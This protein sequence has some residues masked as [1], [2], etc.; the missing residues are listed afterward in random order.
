MKKLAI[1]FSFMLVCT[2]LYA[3]EIRYIHDILLVP[4]RSGQSIAHRIVH[5]GLRSGTKLVLLE[6][7]KETGYSKVRTSGG[8]EGWLQSQYIVSEPTAKLKLKESQQKAQQL[9]KELAPLKKNITQIKKDHQLAQQKISQLQKDNSRLS[10]ELSKIKSIAANAI[11]LDRNNKSLLK[12]NELLENKV[13]VLAADNERL[14]ENTEQDAFLNGVIAVGF[15]VLLTLL[16][17]RLV[18][19]KRKFSEWG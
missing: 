2:N 7:N 9:S 3:E 13:D 19:R 10:D 18:P 4:V 6:E 8:T 5:K 12:K 1:L 15:G 11:D 16:I 14:K 17:P